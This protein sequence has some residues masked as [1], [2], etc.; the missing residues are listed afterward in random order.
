MEKPTKTCL[1]CVCGR[2]VETN[3]PETWARDHGW[4]YYPRSAHADG[5]N[6]Y[7]TECQELDGEGD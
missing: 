2:S 5:T 6:A 3:E 7:C 4:R 1:L